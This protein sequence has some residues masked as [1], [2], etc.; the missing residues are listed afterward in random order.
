MS[1]VTYST[2]ASTTSSAT[3]SGWNNDLNS[4]TSS[5]TIWTAWASTTTSATSDS[6]D[7]TWVTWQNVEGPVQYVHEERIQTPAQREEL[8][9]AKRNREEEREAA[10]QRAKNLLLDLIGEKQ[11]AIYEETGRLFVKG[12]KFDYIIPKSGFIKRVEKDKITDLCVHLD[13]RY[14]YPETDNVIA[15]KLALEDEEDQ[16]LELANE[17]SS[18]DRPEELPLA[19]CM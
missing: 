9:S 4:T 15:L 11:L 19:A 5:G 6:S 13:N 10:E 16:I 8:Q 3:W 2:S 17:F 12:K 14:K 18:R 1:Y 7:T